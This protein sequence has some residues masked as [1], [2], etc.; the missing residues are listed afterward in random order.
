MDKEGGPKLVHIGKPK[1]EAKVFVEPAED[2]FANYRG[3]HGVNI[4]V[5]FK[6][7]LC[8]RERSR[9]PQVSIISTVNEKPSLQ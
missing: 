4:G 7:K 5:E 6:G 3:H 8:G 1:P 2:R 9:S